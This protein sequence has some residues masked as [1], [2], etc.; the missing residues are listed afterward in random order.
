M[1]KNLMDKIPRIIYYT[2][3]KKL[4]KDLKI[5]KLIEKNE[6]RGFETKIF[7]TNESRN[8]IKNNF[9][10]EVLLCYDL[11]TPISYKSD[12]FRYCVLYINGG[13]YIDL[14]V[15]IID[16]IDK[17]LNFDLVLVKDRIYDGI[18]HLV[19]N[20]FIMAK[21]N[22]KLFMN[23]INNICKKVFAFDK[24][25]TSLDVTGPS[26]FGHTINRYYNIKLKYKNVNVKNT[27][28]KVLKWNSQVKKIFDNHTKYC[29]LKKYELHFSKIYREELEKTAGKMKHRYA[30]LWARNQVFTLITEGSW[31]NSSKNYKISNGYF[32]VKCRNV[33]GD[34]V[35]N[36]VKLEIGK[37]K[38]ANR[39]GKLVQL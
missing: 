11:L 22:N 1:N 7:D 10:D 17:L 4:T 16:S 2:T 39:N 23:C 32:T 6:K 15:L 37:Y 25:K 21:P 3:D 31:S 30:A 28:I 26:L 35:K 12:L 18:P 24:G 9:P 33:K 19:W 13:I 5:Y 29:A 14:G 27:R 38:Y 20:G 34:Y 8:F 36:K